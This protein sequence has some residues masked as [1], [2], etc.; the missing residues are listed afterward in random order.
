MMYK[1]EM[2]MQKIACFL[3]LISSVVVFLYSLG[4]MTDLYESFYYTIR[5]PQNADRNPIP[6]SL[7]FYDMQPFNK[8]F[9]HLGLMLI[10]IALLLFITSTHVRRRYYVGNVVAVAANLVANVAVFFWANGKIAAYKIQFL[11]TVDFDAFKAFAEQ[12]GSYYTEST[13]WFDVRTGVF[14]FALICNAFM[15]IIMLW[16]FSLMKQE[17]DLIEEG[18]GAAS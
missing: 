1:K 5:D 16:K 2:V 4:I 8:T 17:K 13:F 18:K 9:L 7:I 6:G 14:A 12:R 15:L 10:I 3:V 11:T